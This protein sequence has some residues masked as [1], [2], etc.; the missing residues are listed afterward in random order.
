MLIGSIKESIR[1]KRCTLAWYYYIDIIVVSLVS[2]SIYYLITIYLSEHEVIPLSDE[3]RYQSLE[4]YAFEITVYYFVS[5]VAICFMFIRSLRILNSI[6]PSFSVLFDT[7]RRSGSDL[8]YFLLMAFM[9]LMGFVLMAYIVFG[10][11]MKEFRNIG[12]S[13]IQLFVMLMGSIDYYEL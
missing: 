9:L 12:H 4:T 7:I 2:V 10:A 3:A 11:G 6:F 13:F 1:I 8:C 5:S